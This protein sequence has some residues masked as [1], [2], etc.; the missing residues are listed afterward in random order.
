MWR[1]ASLPRG[2]GRAAARRW[3]SPEVA[4]HR[5]A[6]LRREV[7]VAAAEA[8]RASGV[9]QARRAELRADPGD[10]AIVA[11]ADVAATSAH[12]LGIPGDRRDPAQLGRHAVPEDR[13]DLIRWL[14]RRTGEPVQDGGL[15]APQSGRFVPV[16]LVARRPERPI[17]G[18]QVQ[19]A[20]RA[21]DLRGE[22]RDGE[23]RHAFGRRAGGGGVLEPAIPITGP[24]N[25]GHDPSALGLEDEHGGFGQVDRGPV[26]ALHDDPLAAAI[27]AAARGRRGIQELGAV[28]AVGRRGGRRNGAGLPRGPLACGGS[29]LRRRSGL[30]R[31]SCLRRGRRRRHPG[32]RRLDASL[33]C[34]RKRRCHPGR[35]RL[36]PGLGRLGLRRRSRLRGGSPPGAFG[37]G[38]TWGRGSPFGRGGPRSLSGLACRR[39][40]RRGSGA[41]G[42]GP[43]DDG[44]GARHTARRRGHGRSGALHHAPD[45]GIADRLRAHKR[46]QLFVDPFLVGLLLGEHVRCRWQARG[47]RDCAHEHGDRFRRNFGQAP[48]VVADSVAGSSHH[49]DRLGG[50]GLVRLGHD[51]GELRL[52]IAGACEA[53]RLRRDDDVL[54][55]D[56]LGCNDHDR[57]GWR[58]RLGSGRDLGR[59]GRR[60]DRGRRRV[61]EM[62][63]GGVAPMIVG[64]TGPVFGNTETM[65]DT[66]TTTMGG[67]GPPGH[68]PGPTTIVE[69]SGA[70]S[71][72]FALSRAALSLA[73][74]SPSDGKRSPSRAA[75]RIWAIAH[76]ASSIFGFPRMNPRIFGM[77]FSRRALWRATVRS[78]S[79]DGQI[80]PYLPKLVQTS[81]VPLHLGTG[82][83]RGQRVCTP[84]GRLL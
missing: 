67:R 5:Q 27:A 41:L 71:A 1:P 26:D 4:A 23:L 75:V 79:L 38:R 2:P 21:H 12:E 35:G 7:P 74:G 10:E 56:R 83:G 60:D 11:P 68:G 39:S 77:L 48:G 65:S 44:A 33:W 42:L 36:D 54:G 53:D 17:D 78:E 14:G 50:S 47:R 34:G 58:R 43:G 31:R 63:V 37:R 15:V 6:V 81:T 72:S 52:A 80:T 82:T 13:D 55:D 16:A 62:I 22:S 19:L 8:P 59:R 40:R 9:G 70:P 51:R 84:G 3:T 64:W 30:R 61:A 32:T 66:P 49:A 73:A 69:G 24:A 76:S 29:R 20:R 57:V 45:R 28:R 18:V 25:R 46:C